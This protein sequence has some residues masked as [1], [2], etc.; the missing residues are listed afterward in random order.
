M[1]SPTGVFS[2]WMVMSRWPPNGPVVICRLRGIALRACATRVR[3]P[4]ASDGSCLNV[5]P[6]MGAG[7]MS[8]PGWT[9]L[10]PQNPCFR[11]LLGVW[12]SDTPGFHFLF[13]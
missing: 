5:F 3:S 13:K 8:D 1:R 9:L 6:G 10:L 12:L 11:A 4:V 7:G 2:S